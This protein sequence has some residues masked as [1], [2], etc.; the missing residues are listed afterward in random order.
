MPRLGYWWPFAQTV[1]GWTV[2]TIGSIT[3]LYYG[4]K[5][6]LDTFDWYMDRF[7]DYKVNDFLH[8]NVVKSK[9]RLPGGRGQTAMSKTVGE[10]AKATNIS[11]KRVRGCLQRLQRKKSV[12]QESADRWRADVPPVTV[13]PE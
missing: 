10:I 9:V 5:K 7:V 13:W 12:T 4:T 6:L 1:W 3:A 11:E 8:S 2:A